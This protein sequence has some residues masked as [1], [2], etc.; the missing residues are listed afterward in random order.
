MKRVLCAVILSV[1]V[2]ACSSQPKRNTTSLPQIAEPA[3]YTYTVKAVY[4]HLTSSYTQGLQFVDGV[5]WEGTGE[6][7]K[8]VL[9]KIDLQ[10]GQ[11]EVLARLPKSEFGE[12][13]TVLGDR[14]YQ[15]TWTN[16]KVH[17]YDLQ[18]NH[19]KD[20]RYMGEG[21]G[22]TSDG[23]SLY[24]SNGTADIYKVNP[25][26]FKRESKITVTMRGEVLNYLN[27]LEW[28]D[29]KIWAN[30]YTTDY[31]VIINPQTGVVEAV[32]DFKGLLKEEDITDKTDVLNGIAYDAE[33]GRIFVTG[34][35]WNKLFEVEIVK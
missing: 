28:I 6:W 9:Q 30:V 11:A 17:I 13:I 23:E 33:G 25:E 24:M 16:N 12:G 14:V 26:T 32:I 34:K 20:L 3:R 1:M 35:S 22:L 15:L 2:V 19:Q 8:S 10:S 31:V 5:M 29:G 27:E 21:W 4:P 7:G 18:G